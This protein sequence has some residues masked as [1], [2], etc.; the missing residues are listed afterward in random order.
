MIPGTSFLAAERM[1]FE[2]DM[3]NPAYSIAHRTIATIATAS[4]ILRTVNRTLGSLNVLPSMS[5]DI[6]RTFTGMPAVRL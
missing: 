6:L 2:G 1:R 4:I 5:L 3:L